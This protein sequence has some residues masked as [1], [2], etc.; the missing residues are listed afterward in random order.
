MAE[1]TSREENAENFFLVRRY[2]ERIRDELPNE[3]LSQGLAVKVDSEA[4]RQHKGK[5]YIDEAMKG[6]FGEDGTDPKFYESIYNNKLSELESKSEEVKLHWHKFQS[7]LKL[8]E[9]DKIKTTSEPDMSVLRDAIEEAESQLQQKKESNLGKTKTFLKRSVSCLDKYHYLFDLL[10]TGDKYTSIFT[11]SLTAIVKATVTHEKIA[12]EMSDGFDEISDHVRAFYFVVKDHPN[13]MYIKYH[14]TLFYYDL[15]GF[16]VIV[17]QQWYSSSWR[18]IAKSLGDSF[19]KNV[20][21]TLKKLGGYT[22]KIKEEDTRRKSENTLRKLEA[23]GAMMEASL[24]EQARMR[25]TQERMA[26]ENAFLS[27][28]VQQQLP[29]NVV[30]NFLKDTTNDGSMGPPP[31]PGVMMGS[32]T[33]ETFANPGPSWSQESILADV[34]PLKQYLQ[35][36]QDVNRLVELSRSIAVNTEISI[37]LHKWVTNPDSEALW[38][39]GPYGLSYP[40]QSTLTSAF[41]VGNLRRVGIPVIVEFCQYKRPWDREKELLKVI[42]GL[43]YQAATTLEKLE[44]ELIDIDFTSA[45]FQTLNKD[46]NVSTL[47]AAIELFADLVAVGPALQFFI[48]DGLQLF[49]GREHSPLVRKSLRSLVN[50]LLKAVKEASGKDKVVKVLFTTDGLVRELAS[51]ERGKLLSRETY[52]NEDEDEL[53]IIKDS[54]LGR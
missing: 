41:M 5:Y 25:K 35:T 39:E 23:L 4:E 42:Y 50:I 46:L 54:D 45:R 12:T 20:E 26:M 10:P 3:P 14:I 33:E 15:F 22:R 53:L 11:G 2:S 48:I 30:R 17:M 24:M 34:E 37:R 16:L 8:S 43:I 13:S 7:K 31:R 51:G 19:L 36:P 1:T 40:T 18:R 21:D 29:P 28:L 44:P 38:I 6:M 49:D 32:I 27:A 9:V 47:P 52:E